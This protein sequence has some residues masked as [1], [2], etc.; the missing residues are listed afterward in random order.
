MFIHTSI[1]NLVV[2]LFT[3]FLCLKCHIFWS[4][5][6]NWVFESKILKIYHVAINMVLVFSSLGHIAFLLEQVHLCKSRSGLLVSD[7]Y[8]LTRW[9]QY[10]T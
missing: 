9:R 3:V 2:L 8:D 7:V 10:L 4:F 5:S 6:T 1:F